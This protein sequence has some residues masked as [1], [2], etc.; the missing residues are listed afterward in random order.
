[1]PRRDTY[2]I[3][4]SYEHNVINFMENRSRCSSVGAEIYVEFM[5]WNISADCCKGFHERKMSVKYT[6]S[7]K[8]WR[9][10]M[11]NMYKHSQHMWE[12]LLGFRTE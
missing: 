6:T 8:V 9:K 3:V 5:R 2:D 1:M 12:L 11:I 4:T 10:C 7:R